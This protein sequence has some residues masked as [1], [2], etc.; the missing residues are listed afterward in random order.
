MV[1]TLFDVFLSH[2]LDVTCLQWNSSGIRFHPLRSLTRGLVLKSCILSA[3]DSGQGVYSGELRCSL[4]VT[5][6]KRF[7][8]IIEFVRI[9]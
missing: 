4:N 1:G 5:L 3:S 2:S 7:S 6:S 8:D 9:L